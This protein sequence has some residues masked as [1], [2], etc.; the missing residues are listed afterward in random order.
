[1][2]NPMSRNEQRALELLEMYRTDLAEA[3]GTVEEAGYA[4]FNMKAYLELLAPVPGIPLRE[5]GIYF[6]DGDPNNPDAAFRHY[7]RFGELFD[8]T[9]TNGATQILL[10]RSALVLAYSLWEDGYRNQISHALRIKRALVVDPVLG[11][12]RTY[13]N[14][15]VHNTNRQS[16]PT[17]HFKFFDVGDVMSFTSEQFSIIFS[18]LVGALNSL[19]LKHCGKNPGFSMH[20][21]LYNIQSEGP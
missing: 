4:F 1:M 9:E 3:Y 11:D 16:R 13:R 8:R 19:A 20:R 7:T 15:I 18:D 14:S 6:G 21:R 10:R 5:R 12:L 17:E 2:N